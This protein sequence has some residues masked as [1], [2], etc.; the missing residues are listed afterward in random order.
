MEHF[1]EILEVLFFGV[2]SD[3]SWIA[4]LSPTCRKGSPKWSSK[5]VFFYVFLGSSPRGGL[6]GGEDG[7][8]EMLVSKRYRMGSISEA[9]G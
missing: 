9:F 5:I 1:L 3:A 7:F 6:R 8:V 2:F 4:L